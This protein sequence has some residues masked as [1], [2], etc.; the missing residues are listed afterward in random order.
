MS[1]SV[2]KAFVIAD[3]LTRFRRLST[4]VL[5]GIMLAVA[6]MW[7]PDPATGRAV[8][9]VDRQRALYTAGTIGLATAAIS[10]MFVGLFGFYAI[11]NAVSRD[12]RSRVGQ[13]LAST[14]LRS[15]TYI[16][17]RFLGNLAFLCSLLAVFA[18]GSFVMVLIRGEGTF[19]P[20][21]FGAQYLLICIP[22]MVTVSALAILFEVTPLLRTRA[23]DI[24]FFVLWLTLM[25]IN[26]ATA[27]GGRA[28]WFDPSGL[29]W[30]LSSIKQQTGTDSLSIGASNF[31]VTKPPLAFDGI[32][33]SSASVVSRAANALAPLALLLP[34]MMMFHRFDPAKVRTPSRNEGSSTQRFAFLGRFVTWI[35]PPRPRGLI[36]A[37]MWDARL[38][39]MERPWG[40]I[41]IAVAWIAALADGKGAVPIVVIAGGF[42]IAGIAAREKIGG[43]TAL[44][45]P[46]PVIAGRSGAWKFATSIL[47]LLIVMLPLL[48]RFGMGDPVRALRLAGGMLLLAGIANLLGFLTGGPRSFIAILLMAVYIA[49]NDAA[50][51]IDFAGFHQTFDPSSAAAWGVAAIS[52]VALSLFVGRIARA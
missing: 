52:A 42:L 1:F 46:S 34:A 7:I 32:P 43:T 9:V 48:I 27:M 11:S 21:T 41:V 15:A 13:M 29:G 44:I 36:T 30:V 33:L 38:T 12:L 39:F 28:Q 5:I 3:V 14:P 16:V 31:D 22:A 8:I 45:G 49:V 17:G 37:A 2:L 35:V 51:F 19:D 18:A 50:S 20:L 10:T 40:I 26:S 24:A 6:W 4:L 47:V 25:G 23:G